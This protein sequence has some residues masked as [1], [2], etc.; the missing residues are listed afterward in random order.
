MSQENVEVVERLYSMASMAL[1]LDVFAS[2]IEWD[3]TNFFG[4]TEKPV[5]HGHE[6]VREMMRDWVGSFH[7]WDV[8]LE[9]AEPS[10]DEVLA[11]VRER[12]YVKGISQPLVRRNAAR[13][14]FRGDVIVRARF[15]S[16][17]SEALKAVGLEE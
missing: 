11:V 4:W 7:S 8:T 17:V 9:R 16:E 3:L 15:Y 1:A 5:Y 13:F 6:G 14:T 10:G 12:A 2:D